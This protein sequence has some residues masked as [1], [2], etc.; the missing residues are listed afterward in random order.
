MDGVACL[1]RRTGVGNPVEAAVLGVPASPLLLACTGLTEACIHASRD[2]CVYRKL[3]A[4][5][6]FTE[7]TSSTPTGRPRLVRAAWQ[8]V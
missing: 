4:A 7:L 2:T 3:H 5:L 1:P 8:G 6:S